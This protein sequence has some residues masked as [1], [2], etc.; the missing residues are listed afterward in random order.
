LWILETSTG[1]LTQLTD[2]PGN[3]YGPAWSSDGKQIAFVSTRKSGA[4][5]Y[6]TNVESKKAT[7]LHKSSLALAGASW[8][9][10]GDSIIFQS[11]DRRLNVSKLNKQSLSN[12]DSITELSVDDADVFPFR[13][14]AFSDNEILYTADGGL[15]VVN[16]AGRH[17]RTIPFSLTVELDRPRYSKKKRKLDSTKPRDAKG[18]HAPALSPDGKH[19]AFGALGDLW[20]LGEDES[21]TQLTDDP[22]IQTQ[23]NWSAD[24]KQIAYV[25]DRNGTSDIW[26]HDLTTG[27]N[28][29][30]VE[31]A[32][33]VTVPAWSPDGDAIA[34]IERSPANPTG[35]TIRV[36]D[37]ESGTSKAANPASFM[38][39]PLSWTDDGKSVALTT[40]NRY[41]TK[42]REGAYEMMFVPID[43]SETYSVTPSPHRSLSAGQLS[44]NG[45]LLAYSESGLL[46][47]DS[48]AADGSLSGEPKI[49]SDSIADA[50]TWSGDSQH[51]AYL[52]MDE[53][54]T[55]NVDTEKTRNWK[56]PLKWTPEKNSTSY[57]IHA[58]KMFDGSSSEYH[59]NV[60]II[61]K[62]NRIQDVVPHSDANHGDDW[63]DA[64]DKA[65]IPGLF[66][67]H[68]HQSVLLGEVLG[69]TW[70]AYG[71][72]SVREPGNDAYD[73][74]ERK[75]SWASG[76]RPGPRLFFSGRLFDGNRVYYSLAEGTTSDAHL[77]RELDRAKRLEYDLIKTYVRLP[78]RQQKMVAAAAHEMGIPTSS[79]EIYPAVS[80]G[81]DG[82]EHTGATSRRGYSPKVSSRGRSYNDIRNLLAASKMS[83]T[84]TLTFPGFYVLLKEDPDAF[85]HKQFSVLYGDNVARMH[86]GRATMMA[87][88]GSVEVADA[89]GATSLYVMRNG[90]RVTSG[91]DSPFFPFATALQ[92]ELQ[93]FQRAGFEPW[94]VLRS[95]TSWAA[96]GTGVG[97]DLG[98]IEK[99]KLADMVIIDGD[100]LNDVKDALNITMTI[101]NGIRYP[102]DELLTTPPR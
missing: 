22:F 100:P 57:V 51:I 80:Y 63:I 99:G 47:V 26:L 71:I 21:L 17:I 25:S 7:L 84:P 102:L 35:G 12:S 32:G 74:L 64:G 75:E 48:I 95:A 59:R 30:L 38:P 40:L 61:V 78:D 37:M 93:L 86:K 18:I 67:M 85:N 87:G 53:I 66:E 15:Q 60:D 55:V 49:L 5:V 62:D 6:A 98:S 16:L 70:L 82:V 52:S 69:R 20:M 54:R 76:Q 33:D 3:D 10:D 41:S 31:G 56:N 77:K 13:T 28:T 19:I 68:A 4:G 44:P 91:T 43:G 8:S 72:T 73:A 89:Q 94:E 101:K 92:I 36:H 88:P 14:G 2:D 39:T 45:R 65:V 24:G 79:H 96:E 29:V 46:M 58:G 1:A 34:Y 81:M 11:F 27:S 97:D 42:Y 50:P 23:P 83:F 90:G 9:P